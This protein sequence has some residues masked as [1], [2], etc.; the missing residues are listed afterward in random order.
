MK[1]VLVM[2]ISIILILS[3][4]YGIYDFRLFKQEQKKYG[5]VFSVISA[6]LKKGDSVEG[7]IDY[8]KKNK[9]SLEIVSIDGVHGKG[10]TVTCKVHSIIGFLGGFSGGMH[11]KI[12][13]QNRTAERAFA[14]M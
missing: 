8:L 7:V 12:D 5:M 13:E 4:G 3:I 10:F 9:A 1:K 14:S 2:A 11:V 6:E